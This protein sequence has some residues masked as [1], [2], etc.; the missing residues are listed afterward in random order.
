MSTAIRPAQRYRGSHRRP[1]GVPMTLPAPPDDHEKYLYAERHLPY[2]AVVL[3]IC[4]LAATASQIWFEARSGMWPFG[5]FTAVTVLSFGLALPLSFTGRGFDVGAHVRRVRAWRPSSYP[6]VDIYL[7]ICGEPIDILRNTWAAVFE[8]CHAYP[9]LARSYVLDDG[10]DPQ[11]QRLASDF[12]FTYVVRPD[13]GRCKKSGNLRYAFARTSGEF[14]VVLDADFAPRPDF[15][16]ETLP[17]FDDADLAIIQTP[18]YFRTH[19][20]QTWIERAAGATQEIF[21]RAIQVTRDRLGAAICV[22]SCAVYRS[23]ALAPEGGPT[24]IPYAEDVHTGLDARRNGWRVN[25]IPVVLATGMCPSN[26]DMFVRQQYRWCTGAT[27][28]VLTSRLWT[29]PMSVRARL[30]YLTGFAYY[31]QTALAVFVI[32]LIP[33]CLLIWQP[34]TVRAQNSRLVVMA[35]IA[36]IFLLPV[37]TTTTFRARDVVPLMEI[38]GWAHAL[39]LWDWLRRKTMTWQPSGGRVAQ[40]RRF[41]AGVIAW[42]GSAATA[43][44]ALAAWRTTQFR[45]WQFAIIIIIGLFNAAGVCRMLWALRGTGT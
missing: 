36:G 25:Y 26:V 2:L 43:W 24:L 39:A 9:G 31:V 42:N 32:P 3:V 37:W 18:Q 40:E 34:L 17:Y 38:R 4:F 5:I 28:T 14:F 6:D 30:T 35:V 13:P 19:D 27:S 16:A 45:S 15:L 33:I 21:Y 23:V 7:P 29:V 44:L 22:G 11:A 41:R 8:L 20:G 1:T 12:G 10:A